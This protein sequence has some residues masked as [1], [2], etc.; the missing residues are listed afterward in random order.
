[1]GFDDRFCILRHPQPAD[2]LPAAES[3]LLPPWIFSYRLECID[4]LHYS[5]Q[6]FMTVV[7]EVFGSYRKEWEAEAG[8]TTRIVD[9][10]I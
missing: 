2:M 9:K 3:K 4:Q 7:Q 5:Q 8:I 6:Q 1:L 10:R